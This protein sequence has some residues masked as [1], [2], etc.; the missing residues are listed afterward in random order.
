MNG[1]VVKSGITPRWLM[2]CKTSSI[3]E[4]SGSNPD[5]SILNIKMKEQDIL[6]KLIFSH[7]DYINFKIEAGVKAP[8]LLLS[9]KICLLV[10]ISEDMHALRII[11]F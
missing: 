3:G 2:S 1:L 9:L 5:Q 8:L 4:A 10:G 6:E 7:L 11:L